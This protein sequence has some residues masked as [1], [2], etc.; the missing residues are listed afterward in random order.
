MAHNS[1]GYIALWIFFSLHS[2]FTQLFFSVDQLSLLTCFSVPN[3]F[4]GFC[5]LHSRLTDS[6]KKKKICLINISPIIYHSLSKFQVPRNVVWLIPLGS[7]HHLCPVSWD[8][9]TPL[10]RLCEEESLKSYMSQEAIID[11]PTI[12]KTCN[13]YF[14]ISRERDKPTAINSLDL[15]RCFLL[16]KTAV[17]Y[18]ISL[19]LRW[20]FFE[21]FLPLYDIILYLANPSIGDI[22]TLVSG[23]GR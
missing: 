7:A 8:D 3:D 22:N 2:N 1:Q 4:S 17:D 5:L 23:K 14:D 21:N 12:S 11:I 10:G 15:I 18:W 20:K 13:A 19:S 16:E 6:T 9:D